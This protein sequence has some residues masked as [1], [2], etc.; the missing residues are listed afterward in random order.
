MLE[1]S[2]RPEGPFIVEFQRETVELDTVQYRWRRKVESSIPPFANSVS[3]TVADRAAAMRVSGGNRVV[4]TAEM[5]ASANEA[6]AL[7]PSRLLLTAISTDDVRLAPPTTMQSVSQDVVTFTLDGAQVRLFLNHYTHLPTAV[8]YG[9]PLARAGFWRFAGDTPM[10]TYFSSWKLG[11]RGLR[12][13]MQSD[14]ERDGVHEATYMVRSLVLDPPLS[15]ADTVIPEAIKA[16]FATV[17]STPA[18]VRLG[19][20]GNPA[21]DLATGVTFIPGQWNVTIVRQDDGLIILDAPISSAY[22]ELVISEAAKRYPGM[23]IKAVVSTSDAWPHIA[24][25]R[26]YVARRIPIYCLGINAPA[27]Q[28]IIGGR[29]ETRPD[30]LGTRKRSAILKVVSSATVLG[31]GANR[32]LLFPVRGDTS[33]RQ[34]LAYFP[35]LKL[36][37]GSDVFQQGRDGKPSNTQTASELVDAVTRENISPDRYFM[38]HVDVAGWKDLVS[39]IR[40]QPGSFPKEVAP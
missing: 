32:L 14:V 39:A 33:E 38:M 31:S 15:E 18:T 8:D 3:E 37:Y 27:I 25:L 35:E 16:Q 22:S 2:E 30:A 9:G 28:R 5:L 24:G 26:P 23:P 19:L 10:R 6:M 17:A 21:S 4:G 40:D 20:A 36:L 7:S 29:F 1:Q 13:P 12:L 11:E 34:M